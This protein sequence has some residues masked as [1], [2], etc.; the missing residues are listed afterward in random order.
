ML[1]KKNLQLYKITKKLI[2][3]NIIINQI[4]KKYTNY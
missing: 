2:I 3:F 1:K 4:I